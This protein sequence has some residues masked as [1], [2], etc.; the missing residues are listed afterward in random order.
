MNKIALV[1]P[2]FGKFNN[3]FHLWMESAK[4][5]ETVDFHIYTDQQVENIGNIKVHQT[6][7]SEISDLAVSKLS[8]F[9]KDNNFPNI[10][11]GG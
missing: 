5:N 11:V 9:L 3:Y 10:K 2:Y 1:I 8:K 4:R 6:T 7:L